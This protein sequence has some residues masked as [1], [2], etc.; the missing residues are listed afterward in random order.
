[1][2]IE[3][4]LLTIYVAH[5]DKTG[6][7]GYKLVTANRH[8]EI[9]ANTVLVT[10]DSATPGFIVSEWFAPGKGEKVTYTKVKL[11]RW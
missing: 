2:T 6:F 4:Q 5:S 7:L 1:V 11:K 3:K 8:K 9:A 10:V